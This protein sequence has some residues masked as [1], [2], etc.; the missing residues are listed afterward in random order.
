MT[1][2]CTS[3]IVEDTASRGMCSPMSGANAGLSLHGDTIDG[4]ATRFGRALGRVAFPSPLEGECRPSRDTG[5]AC[6]LPPWSAF[7]T[8]ANSSPGLDRAGGSFSRSPA[9]GLCHLSRPTGPVRRLTLQVCLLTTLGTAPAKSLDDAFAWPAAFSVSMPLSHANGSLVFR[10]SGAPT[11]FCVATPRSI[12]VCTSVISVL[13]R[14]TQHGE[15]R[16]G[17]IADITPSFGGLR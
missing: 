1:N 11:P 2:C 14:W 3:R 15:N 13:L 5:P 6:S 10:S 8:P 9:T 7:T 4:A 17:L 16:C 12:D